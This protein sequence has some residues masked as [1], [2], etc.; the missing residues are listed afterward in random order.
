MMSAVVQQPGIRA[1][2]PSFTQSFTDRVIHECYAIRPEGNMVA[3]AF[4]DGVV[5]FFRMGDL[6]FRH[7]YD[8]PM[9]WPVLWTL[10][11]LGLKPPV[12]E[13]L[14]L[15]ALDNAIDSYRVDQELEQL[16]DRREHHQFLHSELHRGS[17]FDPPDRCRASAV[18]FSRSSGVAQK[19]SRN[20]A[21]SATRSRSAR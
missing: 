15:S 20:P 1:E 16:L 18:A 7:W 9:A 3:F 11:L 17:P 6:L 5:V 13:C 14:S 10:H 21:T 2:T 4:A 8:T 19:S 12:Q